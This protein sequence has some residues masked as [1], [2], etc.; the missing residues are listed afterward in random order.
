MDIK[1]KLQSWGAWS[2]SCNHGLGFISPCLLMMRGNVAESCKAPTA[3]YISDDEA[4]LVDAAIKTLRGE[5]NV[6][7]DIVKLRYYETYTPKEI[8]RYYLTDKEYPRLAHLSWDH[9][10]KKHVKYQHV[11]M[12]IREAERMIERY[13]S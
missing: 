10:D 13:L 9:K 6:L 1:D 5:S 2:R 11:T 12:M 3:Y 8:A 4:M 7:A